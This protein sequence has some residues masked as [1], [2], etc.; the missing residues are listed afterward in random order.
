MLAI[1]TRTWIF[2]LGIGYL[3][4]ESLICVSLIHSRLC[5]LLVHVSSRPLGVRLVFPVLLSIRCSS[6]RVGFGGLALTILKGFFCDHEK[7]RWNYC[8]TLCCIVMSC[9]KYSSGTAF[10]VCFLLCACFVQRTSTSVRV[11]ILLLYV[12][13][14]YVY[15]SHHIHE[16]MFCI[17]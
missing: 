7:K 13:G 17:V 12:P 14:M 15:V 16:Y 9:G 2:F 6:S 8:C 11:R 10:V 3:S 1:H 5:M 4:C